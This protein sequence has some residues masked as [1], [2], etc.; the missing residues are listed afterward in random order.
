VT[1]GS[2]PRVQRL[3]FGEVA[4][5]YDQARPG[6]PSALFDRV[7][8]LAG[9]RPGDSVLEVGAGTGKATAAL[10]ER[11]FDVTAVEP[12]AEMAAVLRRTCPAAEVL[13]GGLEDQE[14]ALGHFAAVVAA[15]SWHWV[16]QKLGPSLVADALAP[17]GWLALFWNVPIDDRSELRREIEAAYERYVPSLIGLSALRKTN[18]WAPSQLEASGR[19]GVAVVESLQWDARYDTA[20]YLALLQTQSDHRL[21]DDETRAALLD[22]VAAA[23]DRHGGWIEHPYEVELVAAPRLG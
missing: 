4:E 3:V 22:A 7:V 2:E 8:E 11:G 12:S 14:L 23:I 13:A 20:G 19:F 16:D 10:L 1:E 21:L 6:Y 15:Q 9:L 18:P 5:L 17:G